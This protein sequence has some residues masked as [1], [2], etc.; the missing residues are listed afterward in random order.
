MHAIQKHISIH[1]H[2]NL[3]HINAT[4]PPTLKAKALILMYK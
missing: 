4:K 2:L 3:I 1:T